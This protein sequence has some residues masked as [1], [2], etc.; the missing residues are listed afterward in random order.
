M[1]YHQKNSIVA[2]IS[3]LLIIIYAVIHF[4]II[5]N[6]K[7]LDSHSIFRLWFIT[8]GLTIGLTIINTILF[9]IG[10]AVTQAVRSRGTTEPV[11][12]SMEDE[13]DHTIKL[14]GS[15][16]GHI[17]FGLGTFAAMLTFVLGSPAL[18]MFSILIFSSITSEIADNT[19]QL[20]LYRKGI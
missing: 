20:I 11:I 7:G 14:K 15:Q 5:L 12:D 16:V 1:T 6:T 13:R 4:L 17:V 2:L 9:H 8:I 18:V 10:D 19:T 3:H